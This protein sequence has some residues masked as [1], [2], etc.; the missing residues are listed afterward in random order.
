MLGCWADV[1]TDNGGLALLDSPAAVWRGVLSVV[2]WAALDVAGV[3]PD[4]LGAVA[5]E[6]GGAGRG[7]VIDLRLR[8]DPSEA[9]RRL[10]AGLAATVL[11]R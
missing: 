10:I 5:A 7:L 9:D 6:T 2:G 11:V 3:A 4:V 1:L 8:M